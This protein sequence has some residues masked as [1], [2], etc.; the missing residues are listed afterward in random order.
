VPAQ[1]GA[2]GRDVVQLV[3]L[4]DEADLA[5]ARGDVQRWIGQAPVVGCGTPDQRSAAI[6]DKGLGRTVVQMGVEDRKRKRHRQTLVLRLAL[7]IAR[8]V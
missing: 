3:P 7:V 2:V 4:V 8:P 5:V 6:E 1:E